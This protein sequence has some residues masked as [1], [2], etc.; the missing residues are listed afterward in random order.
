MKCG[1]AP[2]RIARLAGRAGCWV[3][4]EG[5]LVLLVAVRIAVRWPSGLAGRSACT[6][7]PCPVDHGAGSRSQILIEVTSTVPWKMYSRLS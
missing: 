6:V 7:R 2:D 1:R 4:S 5:S 3:A